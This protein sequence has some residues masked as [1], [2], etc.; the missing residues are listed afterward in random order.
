[1]EK[2][3]LKCGKL[4]TVKNGHYGQICCSRSCAVSSRY[5]EDLGVFRDDVDSSIQNYI[6][7]LIISD[8]CMTRNRNVE[9]VCI[10]LNDYEM[11]EQIR[12]LACPTKKIYQAGKNFQVIWRNSNDWSYLN[13]QGIHE[14]KTYSVGL[15]TSNPLV[16]H[17]IRGIFDGDGCIY[18]SK[19]ND[20]KYGRIY[21]YKVVSITSG[22]KKLI[23]DIGVVL[24]NHGIRYSVNTDSRRTVNKTYYLKIRRKSEIQNFKNWIYENSSQWKLLRKYS[25]FA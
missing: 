6:L 21:S 16:S 1:M 18:E 25:K 24:D 7:G 23:D 5:P 19:T 17:V 22:S 12:N 10:S 13:S 14:R 20:H 4:F 8:G 9:K 3:C 2:K 11:I 15:D